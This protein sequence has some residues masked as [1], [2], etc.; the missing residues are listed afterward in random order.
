MEKKKPG[1]RAQRNAAWFGFAEAGRWAAGWNQESFYSTLIHEHIVTLGGIRRA[2]KKRRAAWE[3]WGKYCL[4]EC[5]QLV[6]ADRGLTRAE[7]LRWLRVELNPSCSNRTLERT[8]DRW[9]K[10]AWRLAACLKKKAQ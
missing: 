10:R 5:K 6:R 8:V 2:E 3:K 9:N 7:V 4:M 1:Q